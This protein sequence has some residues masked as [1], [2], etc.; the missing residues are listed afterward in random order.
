MAKRPAE[1]ANAR[2]EL[3]GRARLELEFDRPALLGT[4]FGQFDQNLI[5]LENRLGVYI[6]ARGNRVAVEGEPAGIARAR[7]VLNDLYG[8]LERGMSVDSGDVEAASLDA[9]EVSVRIAGSGDAE[10]TARKTL[11]VS[12]A[13][14][15]DVRY[16]G[17][18]KLTRSIAG[19]GTVA[20]R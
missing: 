14:S 3:P 18:P 1:P 11:A 6:A 16:R 2:S 5:T 7:D 17:D 8:R 10:V 20:R 15:G 19:S 9:D 13:G 12:I 4:L